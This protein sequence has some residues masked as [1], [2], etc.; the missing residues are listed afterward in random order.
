MAGVLSQATCQGMATSPGAYFKNKL[1]LIGGSSVNPDR[2]GKEV[3][4]YE[5][6][7][8]TQSRYWKRKDD[9]LSAMPARMGHACVLFQDA[10]WV[11][12]GY[13]NGT[14]YRD[15]WQG[16]EKPDGQLSGLLS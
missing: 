15:V 11:I 10:L 12:G 16:K 4:C 1:W 7:P 6:D 2:P 5:K 13:N 3:W 14:A 8:S 9:F